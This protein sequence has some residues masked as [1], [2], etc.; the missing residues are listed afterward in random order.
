MI[1]KTDLQLL[2]ALYKLYRHRCM[3]HILLFF[4]CIFFAQFAV[5]QSHQIKIG[6]YLLPKDNDT[7]KSLVLKM[8]FGK[9]TI[10]HI[11]GDTAAFRKAGEVTVDI[12][13]T[14]YP[15]E[16]SLIKLNANRLKAFYDAFPFIISDM[17][18]GYII[19]G[20]QAAQKKIRHSQCFM[21][22]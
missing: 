17:L 15:P 13:C 19:T 22:W 5:S 10:D 2:A 8:P 9:Y 11:I 6:R 7:E 21:V 18:A 14:D 16:Q 1:Y 4:F 20:K 3:K 12:I